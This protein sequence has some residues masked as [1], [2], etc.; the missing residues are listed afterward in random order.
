MRTLVLAIATSVMIVPSVA[1][2]NAESDV[3]ALV[4]KNAQAIVAG[5]FE[6][7]DATLAPG[8]IVRRPHY[9]HMDVPDTLHYEFFGGVSQHDF[10]TSFDAKALVVDAKAH[11]AWFHYAVVIKYVEFGPETPMTATFRVSGVAVDDH[12]WKL[13]AI[14]WSRVI[15]DKDLLARAQTGRSRPKQAPRPDAVEAR[16]VAHWFDGG[17]IAKDRATAGPTVASGTA[18][19][20]LAAGAAAGKLA[21][22]WDALKMWAF[23]LESK[24]WGS[25]A[26]VAAKVALP[27]KK[28]DAAVVMDLGAVLV[29][30]NGA[31]RWV[32]VAFA[33]PGVVENNP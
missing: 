1:R 21:T 5:S 9:T 20:E 28:R 30:D 6:A 32:S 23:D 17:A 3:D 14:V 11:V 29:E 24:R 18:P 10:S 12:G 31:W 7:F 15:P 25:V 33:P 22:S 27:T 13:A 19:D 2:A 26:F 8:A 16:A 4:R